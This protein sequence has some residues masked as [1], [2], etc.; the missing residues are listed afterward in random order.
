M[1]EDDYPIAGLESGHPTS[2]RCY[3][4]CG[5]MSIDARRLQQVV[6][7]LFQI[8][9]T[10]PT[11]FHTHK[12]LSR[13]D[14]RRWNFFHADNALAAIDGCVHSF[15]YGA[16]IRIANW[17]KNLPASPPPGHTALLAGA[18]LGSGQMAGARFPV[19]EQLYRSGRPRAEPDC[20]RWPGSHFL[21][22]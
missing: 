14:R 13:E 12:N 10:D 15:R 18:V 9:V 1:V 22:P 11:G 17:Q 8:G 2:H 7:D 20:S 19:K 3:Y 4:P 5:L 21:G 6:F 16:Y